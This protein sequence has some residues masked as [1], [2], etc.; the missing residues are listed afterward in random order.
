MPCWRSVSKESDFRARFFPPRRSRTRQTSATVAEVDPKKANSDGEITPLPAADRIEVRC[1]IED[2]N[3]KPANK[4]DEANPEKS[5]FLD[6]SQVEPFVRPEKVAEF[7]GVDKATVVRYASLG[8][9]PGHPIRESGT[10][11]HWRF[12]LSEVRDFMLS[13][14]A[15]KV[16]VNVRAQ[17]QR[18]PK[19]G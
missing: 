19:H 5:S 12:L 10:R 17:A 8:L 3:P 1:A 14:K 9:L 11:I 7:L 13:Q 2:T 16:R 6:L 15:K 4:N 18:T